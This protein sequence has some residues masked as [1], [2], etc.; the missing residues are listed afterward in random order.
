MQDDMEFAYNEADVL[1]GAT[2]GEVVIESKSCWDDC[3]LQ[4]EDYESSLEDEHHLSSPNSINFSE[5]WCH[6]SNNVQESSHFYDG[7][8]IV[9]CG[10]ASFQSVVHV[11][12]RPPITAALSMPVESKPACIERRIIVVQAGNDPE[13]ETS[14]AVAQITEELNQ[15]AAAAVSAGIMPEAETVIEIT[16][17]MESSGQQSEQ[18]Q[19]NQIII[20]N[21]TQ[22]SGVG[23]ENIP[24]NFTSVRPGAKHS[25]VMLRSDE[26][27]TPS[28]LVPAFDRRPVAVEQLTPDQNCA[29]FYFRP[30]SVDFATN[31]QTP[32]V[33]PETVDTSANLTKSVSKPS[34]RF[35][36]L[37]TRGV[38]PPNINNVFTLVKSSENLP[39]SAA[40]GVVGQMKECTDEGVFSK[41]NIS[42][43]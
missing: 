41:C 34:S 3:I 8:R 37:H 15:K 1:S 18:L 19:S 6:D 28:P 26:Y 13:Q 36:P 23:R 2:V 31:G 30:L 10:T 22:V 7:K 5:S 9:D 32:S 43:I 40:K 12:R 25:S 17:V 14:L 20:Q 38:H 21:G 11:Q 4:Y 42:S 16:T 33:S 35:V 29:D 24:P 27:Q 39:R